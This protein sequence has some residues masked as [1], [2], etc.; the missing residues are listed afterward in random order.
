M[1]LVGSSLSGVQQMSSPGMSLEDRMV[2]S[3]KEERRRKAKAALMVVLNKKAP[4]TRLKLR[5]RVFQ[6]LRIAFEESYGRFLQIDLF[7]RER[8]SFLSRC[9]AAAVGVATVE[10]ECVLA[11]PPIE[12]LSIAVDCLKQLAVIALLIVPKWENHVWYSR[13]RER[14]SHYF[15]LPIGEKLWQECSDR[16][17]R[18]PHIAFI[19]D[20]R[21]EKREG[22]IYQ[23]SIDCEREIPPPTPRE[24]LE[25]QPADFLRKRPENHLNTRWLLK[26]GRGPEVPPPL[27]ARTLLDVVQGVSTD[28][29]GGGGLIRRHDSKMT[30]EEE[31]KA[32]ETARE[33]VRKGWAA[34]PFDTPPFPNRAC[35]KQAIVTK[36]FTIPKH[37]WARDRK[38]RLIFHKSFPLGMSINAL[39]PHR[40]VA[41]FFPK[42]EHRYFSLAPL[43]SMI[44]KAGRGTLLIQ[45]DAKDAYKQLRVAVKDLHQ[46]VFT[47][48]GKFWVD[49]AA[50][51][52]SLY[53]SDAYSRFAYVHRCCL[54]RAAEC[55]LLKH[56]VDNYIDLT[57]QRETKE[58]T[59]REA[60]AKVP[61]LKRELEE[62]GLEYHEFE[63]PAFRMKILGWLID[64]LA[65]TVSMTDERRTWI[66]SFLGEW[67]VMKRF[68][69]KQMN[70]LI[71]V[72]IFL[73]MILGGIKAFTGT[74]ME[75]R[76]EMSRNA[77]RTAVVTQRIRATLQHIRFVITEWNG[78]ARI[79]D[80]EWNDDSADLV[81][82]A[83][84]AASDE[85]ILAGSYGKGAFA[86]PSGERRS[87]AWKEDEL[88]EA[89]REVKHS[90][91]HLEL[92]N[93]LE[94]VLEFAGKEQKILCFGD[95]TAAVDIAKARYTA[96]EN[97]RIEERLREF[98]VE[99]CKRDLSVRFRW[100]S[101][102]AVGGMIADA[103]SRGEVTYPVLSSSFASYS[104]GERKRERERERE[105]EKGRGRRR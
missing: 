24:V 52:G 87:L 105:R 88:K 33:G 31:E 98:D 21:F 19:V 27:L 81:V 43:M 57:P 92:L 9:G 18:I 63:G 37:K 44:F 51:F 23:I 8:D 97:R 54:A 82:F 48:G 50:S 69:L 68:Q 78:V 95:N 83:D 36:E 101:R 49:F 20:F 26:W 22:E 3:E 100:Q 56:Y 13:L 86:I 46:Q 89:M 2:A 73:S 71:G 47:A 25:M 10:A 104:L 1:V 29:R 64:T 96:T 58:E 17:W 11:V 85:P 28:Y 60:L 41:S 102:R 67:M 35:N 7:A 94:A 30:P 39:T 6:E 55:P 99:C 34:G 80:R 4:T 76:N 59:A 75:K 16:E 66:I 15:V 79:F 5:E 72:L 12:V 14:A 74:L 42:G 32:L 53:G 61:R 38:L 65:M 91:A 84:I 62:S 45:F 93:M 90:S 77:E 70:S 40:D 103:L